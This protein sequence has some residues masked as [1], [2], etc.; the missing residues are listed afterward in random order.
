MGRSGLGV[1]ITQAR[2]T[3]HER[4]TSEWKISQPRSDQHEKIPSEWPSHHPEAK[5][6]PVMTNVR[7][8]WHE[9]VFKLTRRYIEAQEV[10]V[11]LAPNPRQDEKLRGNSM[12]SSKFNTA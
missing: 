11:H 9:L 3:Q 12:F 4:I 5:V 7:S 2:Q 10:P 1:S 6:S 8:L